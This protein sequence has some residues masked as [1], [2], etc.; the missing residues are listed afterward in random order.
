MPPTTNSD[1]DDDFDYVPP[2]DDDGSDC[3]DDQ[4]Q[5]EPT[6][7]TAP[8]PLDVA[9]QKKQRDALWASFQASLPMPPS[10]AHGTPTSTPSQSSQ[11]QAQFQPPVVKRV[12]IE[13][14]YLFAGKHVTEV[15]EVPE[16]SDDAK[17]WPRWSPRPRLTSDGVAAGTGKEKDDGKGRGEGEKERESD[18]PAP[19]AVDP[20]PAPLPPMT[21][22]TS[23]PG[24]KRPGPRKPWTALPS[25]PKVS[26][27]KKITTLDKTAMDWRAHVASQSGDV[28]TN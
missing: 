13:K 2:A 18:S 19:S 22:A 5:V 24:A 23:T 1:S 9:E 28:K 25:I 4:E 8:P 21:T 26:Q 16:N 3:S 11:A 15:V 17:K 7:G 12:K 10:N 6:P 20:S 27:A 14:T